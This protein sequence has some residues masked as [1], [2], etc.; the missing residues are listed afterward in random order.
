MP[1]RTAGR[2][3]RPYRRARA[4][5]LTISDVCHLCGHGGSGDVDHDP[6]L[7]ELVA[8]GL[9]PNDPAYMRPAHGVLSRCFVCDSVRG[10]ACNQVKGA[11]AA[12][13]PAMPTSRRW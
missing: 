12:G 7:V 13:R 5:V 4:Q 6:P 8:L 2:K 11:R 1:A 10:R 3:G 9:D